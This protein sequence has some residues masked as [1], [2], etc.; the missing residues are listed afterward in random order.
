MARK[1][2]DRIL[3]AHGGGGILMKELISDIVEK[4]QGGSAMPLQDSAVL[5]VE[6]GRI[7]FTT[8][9]F[10][11]SP[12][13]FPGGDIGHLAVCG[14]VNDLAVS[15]ARPLSMSL[16]MIIEEGLEVQTLGRIVESISR[17]AKKA[18]VGIA[19][20]DTKVVERGKADGLYINTTGIGLVPDGVNIGSAFARPGD[21]V[22]IN[23]S[24]G[25]HGLAIM[26]LREGIDFGG[27]LESDTA[28]LSNIIVPLL[29]KVGGVRAMRD[30]TRGGLAAVLNEIA[31]DS[32]VCIRIDE[33]AIP[34]KE[35]VRS[36]CDL[37][38]YDPLHIANEGKFVAV[39][40]PEHAGAALD[41][42]KAHPLGADAAAIGEVLPSPKRHVIMRTP[43]GGER[44]V[45][46]PYG[47]LLPRIC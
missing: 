11:V 6:K 40:A 29:E 19:T 37:M 36:G 46:I 7:A 34:V 45:D 43:F 41:F 5:E 21:V 16:S 1:S 24:V 32:G 44:V 26:S 9:S 35:A 8:D 47:D 4:L 31:S 20:G 25:D 18:G 12:L 3:L 17:A 22:L 28:P 14:T 15:G 38:G 2:D 42:L 33:E 10:V 13:F 30:A 39:V 23:G 27:D